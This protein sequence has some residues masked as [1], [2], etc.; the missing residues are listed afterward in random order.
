M[1]STHRQLTFIFSKGCILCT[2]RSTSGLND[3]HFLSIFLTDGLFL[4]WCLLI[5]TTSRCIHFFIF[6]VLVIPDILCSLNLFLSW[7]SSLE[8]NLGLFDSALKV[9]TAIITQNLV[10]KEA[11]FGLCILLDSPF[12]LHICYDIVKCISDLPVNEQWLVLLQVVLAPLHHIPWKLSVLI[13][14]LEFR[15]HILDVQVKSC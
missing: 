2:C 9:W 6:S 14:W 3:H 11:T 12:L 5:I 1:G 15:I 10:S 4:L 7:L 8:P 13:H